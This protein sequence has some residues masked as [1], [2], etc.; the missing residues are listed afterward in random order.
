MIDLHA[1]RCLPAAGERRETAGG[2]KGLSRRAPE[3][4]PRQARAL[5][6]DGVP[7]GE[8]ALRRVRQTGSCGSRLLGEAGVAREGKAL[9]RG[10]AGQSGLPCVGRGDGV[11]YA[12]AGAEG[13]RGV[14]SGEPRITR[15]FTRFSNRPFGE[16]Q[17][18]LQV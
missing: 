4:N 3:R 13:S 17:K 5:R 15:I 12:A 18:P 2:G 1:E 7:Y 8:G 9:L 10:R 16:R 6:R 11:V 14:R